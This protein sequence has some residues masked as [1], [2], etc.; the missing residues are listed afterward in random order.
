[1]N[2]VTQAIDQNNIDFGTAAQAY[3]RAG[4]AIRDAHLVTFRSKYKYNLIRP[5]S[6]IRKLW[7]ANWLPVIPTPLHPEYP[8]AHAL[9][10][11]ATM[12]AA[13]WVL[14]NVSVIDS[15][16]MRFGPRSF[17]TLDKVGE[18]SG[19]SRLFAGIHYTPSI[20]TGIVKGRKLGDRVGAVKLT[21]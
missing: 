9:I 14:G 17:A 4:I 6:Y 16:Y 10:T 1:M 20:D 8:S 21:E 12:R 5:V 13:K 3:A 18:E 7:E 11:S 19:G 2:I 15:S